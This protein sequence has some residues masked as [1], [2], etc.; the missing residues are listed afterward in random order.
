MVIMSVSTDLSGSIV[1]GAG[2]SFLNRGVTDILEDYSRFAYMPFDN[3]RRE[4]VGLL[5]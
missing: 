1:S 5:S 4:K 2:I 3:A